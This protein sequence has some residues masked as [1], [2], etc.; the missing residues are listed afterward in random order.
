MRRQ[1]LSRKSYNELLALAK[2]QGLLD[3]VNKI[4]RKDILAPIKEGEDWYGIGP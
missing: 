2:K 3:P 4:T 1:G